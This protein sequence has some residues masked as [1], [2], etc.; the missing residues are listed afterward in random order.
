MALFYRSLFFFFGLIIMTFG[1]CLT[2]KA[3]LGVGAWD[4][5]NVALTE[6]IGLT[7]GS[8]V[9]IDGAVLLFVNALLLKKRPE[10]LSLLTIIFIGSLVDFWILI[11]FESWVVS[12]FI[13]QLVT[14]ILG[15]FIIGVGA[16]IYLQAKFPSSPIDTFMMAIKGAFW[17]EFN[18]RK[19][20]RRNHRANSST[21]S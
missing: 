1:V 3:E 17:C 7:I 2:I 5:L 4:A 11:V 21:I 14:L 16:S 8:W 20:H 13:I 15:L 10:L 18:G 9:I 6:W 12:G 19:N